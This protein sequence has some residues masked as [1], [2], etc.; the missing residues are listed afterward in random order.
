[1]TK[2]L[3]WKVVTKKLVTFKRWNRA[4]DWKLEYYS[5]SLKN[6]IFS[7]GGGGG[8]GYTKNQYVGGIYIKIGRGLNS[9]QI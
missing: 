3:N 5:V 1:M 4:K 9:L 2:N 7:G 6:S 8:G